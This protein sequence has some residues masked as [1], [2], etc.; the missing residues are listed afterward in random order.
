MDIREAIRT[1]PLRRY[2]LLT[3]TICFLL[4]MIDGFEILIMA[5]VAP[6]LK[7]DW[8]LDPVQIGYLLSAGLI[9][10]ALGAFLLSPLADRLGRRR[11]TIACL[12]VI[13]V[14]MALSSVA[15]GVADLVVFR[16]FAGLG[17]GGLV[18][19]LNILVSENSNDR[20]RGLTMGL[21]GAGLP[22]GVAVGGAISGLLIPAFTWRAPFVFGT[23]VTAVMLAVVIRSLPESIDYLVEKRPRGALPSYNAIAA[24]LG[25][26]AADRLPEPRAAAE[27]RGV[28]GGLFRGLMGAR[29]LLLWVSYS[30]LMA[31]FYFA[32]SWTPSLLGE[33][34]GDTGLGTTAGVLINV[35]GVLGALAFAVTTTVLRP[36]MVTSL[37]LV[38][39]AAVYLLTAHTLHIVSVSMILCILLG[40]AANGGVAAYYAISPSVYPA[41]VRATGVGLMIGMGRLVSIVAPI[42]TGYLMDAGWG[43]VG[44]YTLFGVVL[45]VAAAFAGALDRSYRGAARIRR[46]RTPGCPM[47]GRWPCG[48]SPR[49]PE[50]VG[51]PGRARA[52]D[53]GFEPTTSDPWVSPRL[54]GD[55]G[56]RGVGSR[57]PHSPAADR[58]PRYGPCVGGIGEIGMRRGSPAGRA[59]DPAGPRRRADTAGCDQAR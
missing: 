42:L 58:P 57:S 30:C 12:T 35:G 56:G 20:R 19:N 52:P 41:A 23:V 6:H 49:P 3:I 27:V 25:Y 33:L 46:P 11:M 13:T 8:G 15:Q 1:Q 45:L 38:F 28:S 31:A 48:R 17:I 9:G 18:A 55:A 16:A 7:A 59:T 14:G 21:Y 39:G 40:M 10:T 5:F 51:P 50:A 37:L 2:Q 53:A 32:N 4:C 26:P 54:R 44:L 24:R 22:A 34:T 47:S 29:T 36:R 43:A